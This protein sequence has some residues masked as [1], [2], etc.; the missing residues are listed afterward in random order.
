MSIVLLL[1]DVFFFDFFNDSSSQWAFIGRRSWRLRIRA[2][3]QFGPSSSWFGLAENGWVDWDHTERTGMNGGV[4]VFFFP[5]F[6]S[7]LIDI[8]PPDGFIAC[9][10][11]FS[12]LVY[13]T[14]A[15]WACLSPGVLIGVCK[16]IIAFVL[17]FFGR[18]PQ[19]EANSIE[20]G[21]AWPAWW[22]AWSVGV[23]CII[24][25]HHG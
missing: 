3:I 15:S 4:N 24:S 1:G 21:W 8:N 16:Q 6:S 7:L 22:I 19:L 13:M 14:L 2:V 9:F 17:G 18:E 23:F 11:C 20:K 25:H 5:W 12:S 10:F